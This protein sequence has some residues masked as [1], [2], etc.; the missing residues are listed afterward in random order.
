MKKRAWA[1]ALA[2]LLVLTGCGKK[3]EPVPDPGPPA[4]EEPIVTPEPEAEPEPVVPAGMNPLTGLP[5]EPEYEQNRPV[6]VMLNNLKKAQPQLGNA[7]ADI[8][9]EVPAEGGITRMLAVYQTLDGIGT[10][11]S[12]RSSRPYYIEL[13]LGH[14]ALYVH[15]GG[16]PE[17]Y[18]DLKSWKVNNIDGVNGSASQSAVFWR[19][20]ERRKTMD[21]EHTLV[22]SGEKIQSFWDGSKYA[23]THGDGY[24]YSQT[25]TDEPL[26][27]G[28]TAEHVK[29]AYTS[30]K[31]GLFDYDAATGRYLVSQY[32]AP[33]V[34]GNTGEQVSA[35]NL[36]LLE[37]NISVISGDK[38]GRLKVRTNADTPHDAA[39]ARKFGAQGIGLCRTE[40]MF[41]AE[42]RIKAVREM[43]CA[44][45]VEEREAALAKVEPFQQGDFEAMYRIMG[46]R[47]M[48]IRYLDPPLH[49][50]LPSKDEDIKELAADMGMTFDD[51]KNVVA[52]LH[53]FNPMMGHRGCR[54]AVTYP[55]IAA[56]QTRAVIKAALNVSA[57]TGY[58]I[59]PHIMIP[60]VGE[61]K[62]LKFVKDVVVKVADE[63]IK[64]SGVDMKYLVGTMIEIPRAALTAGEIAKEA[65]FFSFGTNDLT[66]MTFGFSRDDAAK[67]LGAYYENKIYESDPFQHLDQIGVGKLV[68]MAAHDGRE[69]RPD[70]G[71]GICGEHGGDPS[72]VEFCHNVG[73]D[74]VSCS[75]FR[76]PIARLAAAQAAIK[77]PRA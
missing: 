54:L 76:V 60:L 53:E 2:F 24:T 49:E 59:T 37:T 20:Q 23:K 13:A 18:Q 43:I 50:F 30:Y 28:A 63:L 75:P 7:Q 46:E 14:D 21:Y 19:D 36:L 70:L 65:E 45:T 69:T 56:M 51:L 40:H 47:P 16:S 48:T 38:E 61:V 10:L 1:L 42:D 34:D 57:E 66:Q 26:T 5:M 52:S 55:E 68:K 35:V 6:A 17:A 39:Q 9:Y 73:L 64:A 31:T 29:L 41:F 15:A 32:Q 72:S 71:L 8:I 77:K 11:G 3:K 27:G 25:F 12:I 33:Y 22:T 58:V 44:R 62:E 4:V 74:Y 67:F